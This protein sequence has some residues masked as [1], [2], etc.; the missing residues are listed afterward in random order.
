MTKVYQPRSS[1]EWTEGEGS[2]CTGD[3]KASGAHLTSQYLFGLAIPLQYLDRSS[4]APS[5]EDIYI[6]RSPLSPRLFG[7]STILRGCP[8]V[9]IQQ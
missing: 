4:Q 8:E 7:G 2:P 1:G 9:F 3:V 6:Y 5:E